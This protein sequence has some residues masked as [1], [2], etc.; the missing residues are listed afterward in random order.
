MARAGPHPVIDHGEPAG[1]ERDA[2][3]IHAGDELA[4]GG[5]AIESLEDLVEFAGNTVAFEVGEVLR[6]PRRTKAAAVV[7]HDP[8]HDDD[9]TDAPRR[10]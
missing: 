3:T 7:A 2:L 6:Q 1:G 5:R 10:H 4:F 8:G 9:A